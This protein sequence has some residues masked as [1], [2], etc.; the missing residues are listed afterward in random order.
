M[1]NIIGNTGFLGLASQLLDEPELPLISAEEPPTFIVA[2]RDG[3]WRRA[4]LEEMK[5][6]EDNGTWELVD[7]SVSYRPIGLN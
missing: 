5:A 7:P 3:N 1:D 4:M 2:E 6:I